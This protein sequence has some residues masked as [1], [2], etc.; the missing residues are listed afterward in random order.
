MGVSIPRKRCLVVT[1]RE[2]FQG[3]FGWV[4]VGV[5]GLAVFDDFAEVPAGAQD[6]QFGGAGRAAEVELPAGVAGQ[7]GEDRL[8][9]GHPSAVEVTAGG[10]VQPFDHGLERWVGA[11]RPVRGGARTH[12]D[13]AQSLGGGGQGLVRGEPG[14][15]EVESDALIDPGLVQ[16][17]PGRGEAAVQG[18]LVTAGAVA[19][20]REHELVAVDG[21][22]RVVAQDPPQLG[23]ALEDP[24]AG[25]G[26]VAVGWPTPPLEARQVKVTQ[27]FLVFSNRCRASWICLA[28][29]GATAA[30]PERGPAARTR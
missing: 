24:S 14:V 6:G 16:A 7:V 4:R 27:F 10:A 21:Q 22:D 8:D 15:G 1:D 3:L 13:Q 9:H 5:G 2:G 30:A 17:V 28:S 20:Q 12:I 26:R 19:L 29:S 18:A 23:L 25:I 11:G